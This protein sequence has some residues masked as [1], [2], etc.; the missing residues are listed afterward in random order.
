MNENYE[1]DWT[2]TEVMTTKEDNKLGCIR[3]KH[4]M[5]DW[6]PA[7][8]AQT[9]INEP[10]TVNMAGVEPLDDAEVLDDEAWARYYWK[11]PLLLMHGM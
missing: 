10:P 11:G 8:Q 5:N 2:Y 3:I 7:I 6:K 1:Y 9:D 4:N